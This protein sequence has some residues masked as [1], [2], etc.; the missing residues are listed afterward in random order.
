MSDFG[1]Y[2]RD[3]AVLDSSGARPPKIQQTLPSGTNSSNQIAPW[4]S[5]NGTGEPSPGFGTSFY[6]DSSDNLSQASALSPVF[7]PGTGL[8]GNTIASSDSTQDVYGDERRPSVASVTTASSSGSKSSSMNRGGIHKK[9]QTFFG[10]DLPSRDGS[11][12]SLSLHGKEQK[13]RHAKDVRSN[14]FARSTRERN[15]SSATARDASPSDSRPRTPVPS[16]DVVPFLYQEAQ[17][18]PYVFTLYSRC[19]AWTKLRRERICDDYA[20]LLST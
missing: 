9:L 5:M 10:E 4:M 11:D 16:S 17:V 15:H 8:T 7:R 13:D 12:T 2:R 14:S 18:S 19:M 6:N 20:G 3:L 1:N